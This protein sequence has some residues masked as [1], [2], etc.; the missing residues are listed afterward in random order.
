[1]CWIADEKVLTLRK[2]YRDPFIK[3]LGQERM[4]RIFSSE[5]RFHQL[6]IKSMRN[7]N[8]RNKFNR[9]VPRRG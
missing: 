9:P 7:Q 6:L 3:V 8:Q 4:N 1:M 2:R 5:G